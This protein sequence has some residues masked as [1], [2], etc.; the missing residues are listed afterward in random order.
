MIKVLMLLAVFLLVACS[1]K[2]TVN[3]TVHIETEPLKVPEYRDGK[4]FA[5]T[6][7]SDCAV[8]DDMNCTLAS[9]NRRYVNEFQLWAKY[10]MSQVYSDSCE[11]E[12]TVKEINYLPICD[13][14]SCSSRRK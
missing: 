3:S 2:K 5:C 14:G 12:T 10:G 7:D 6:K 11:G 13:A 8:V 1:S 9:V 4:W